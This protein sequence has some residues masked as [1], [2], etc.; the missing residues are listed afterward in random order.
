MGPEAGCQGFGVAFNLLDQSTHISLPEGPPVIVCAEDSPGS[1][2]AFRN[3][4]TRPRCTP[5]EEQGPLGAT[6]MPV[7]PG[8]SWWRRVGTS[9]VPGPDACIADQWP[10]PLSSVPSPLPSL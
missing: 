5:G 8:S 7:R 9:R 4:S 10:Q 6:P 1:P 3:I 2:R